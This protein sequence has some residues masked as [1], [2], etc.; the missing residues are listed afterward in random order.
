MSTQTDFYLSPEEYLAIEREAEY[1]SEYSDGVMYAMAGASEAHNLI[2]VNV[3]AELHTQLKNTQ[4]KMYPSDM[5][6]RLPG[7]RKFYYPDVSVVCGETRFADQ[8]RDVYLNPIL[9][10]EV[11]SESTAA[12]DRGKKW[13]SYQQLESLQE[14]VLVAQDEPLVERFVRQPR[15]GWLY[16]KAAGIG[17]SVDL[18]SVDCQ[19]A[20]RDLYAKVL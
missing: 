6:V 14:Y 18:V 8:R 9:V 3:V 11:L 1:K 7:G 12:Y 16:L 19:L 15:G 17:E 20:L 2:V 4:C 13:L 10:I 5:K